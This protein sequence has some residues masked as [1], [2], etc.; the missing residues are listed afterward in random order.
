MVGKDG[1]DQLDQEINITWSQGGEEYILSTIKGRKANW[2]GH[3]LRTNRL[4]Q[5]VIAGK[6]Q[7]RRDWKTRK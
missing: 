1:E 6:I 7:G 5:H 2:I 3:I 4:L